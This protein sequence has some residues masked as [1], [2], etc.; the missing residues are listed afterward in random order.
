MTFCVTSL[1]CCGLTNPGKTTDNIADLRRRT[2]SINERHTEQRRPNARSDRHRALMHSSPSSLLLL[3][4][5]PLTSMRHS[6][7]PVRYN[8]GAQPHIKTARA[9]QKR[10]YKHRRDDKRRR[11]R[12]GSRRAANHATR[13]FFVA[14]ACF[15][16]VVVVIVA[17]PRSFHRS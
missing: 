9:K 17:C 6:H 3:H 14:F 13:R 1:V 16:V 12:S 7:R 10:T 4:L 11:R 5:P 15:V 2:I 8:K